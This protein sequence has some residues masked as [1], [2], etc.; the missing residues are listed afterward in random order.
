MAGSPGRG[1]PGELV[2][3][4]RATVRHLLH[5]DPIARTKICCAAVSVSRRITLSGT[6]LPPE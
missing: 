1:L 3:T 6:I 4:A 2:A 5:S